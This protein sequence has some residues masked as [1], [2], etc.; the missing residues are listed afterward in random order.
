MKT[1][2][3][4]KTVKKY[5]I[6]NQPGDAAY[7]RTKTPQERLAALAQI[8]REYHQWRYHAE[9]GLQRVYRIIKQK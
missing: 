5:K 9:P 7:W 3:I 4:Q 6:G 8:R 1:R 2:E